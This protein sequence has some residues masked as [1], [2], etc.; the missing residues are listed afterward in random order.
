MPTDPGHI[1]TVRLAF[2]EAAPQT[3]HYIVYFTFPPVQSAFSPLLDCLSVDAHTLQ[4]IDNNTL[5]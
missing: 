2:P 1:F 3:I 4:Q 5:T